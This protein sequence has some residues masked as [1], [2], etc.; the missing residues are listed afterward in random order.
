MANRGSARERGY[1]ATHRAEKER[2]RPIVNDGHAYCAEIIC[3]EDNNGNGRWIEPGTEWHLAHD[4]NQQG[5]RGP[6]HARCN[7]SEASKRMHAT[8]A[9]QK[10]TTTRWWRP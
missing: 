6:A 8:R 4:T 9:A 5:Y 3:L 2:W 7:I 10:P 1:D